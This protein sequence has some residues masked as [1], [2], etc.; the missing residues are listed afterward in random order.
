MALAAN[1]GVA[2]LAYRFSTGDANM[3]STPFMAMSRMRS[4][5]RK[6]PAFRLRRLLI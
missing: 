4:A 3:R 1:V 5:K 6:P 2:L